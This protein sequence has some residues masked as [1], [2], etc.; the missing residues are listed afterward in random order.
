MEDRLGGWEGRGLMERRRG[1]ANFSESSLLLSLDPVLGITKPKTKLRELQ[2]QYRN[3]SLRDSDNLIEGVGQSLIGRSAGA[4][5]AHS[6]GQ[7]LGSVPSV[8][9]S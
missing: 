4:D 8:E 6:L 9:L 1:T 2:L 5:L 3:V 7:P